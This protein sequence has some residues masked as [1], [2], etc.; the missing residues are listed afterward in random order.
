M[1]RAKLAF[2][3]HE[4]LHLIQCPIGYLIDRKGE[5]D[6]PRLLHPHLFPMTWLYHLCIRYE[7]RWGDR[8]TPPDGTEE[9]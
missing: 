9:K 7:S 3:R 8:S 4:A 6:I 2:V 1:T 5:R